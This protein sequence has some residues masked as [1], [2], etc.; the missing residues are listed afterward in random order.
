[1][2]TPSP[3][4]PIPPFPVE[5]ITPP[6]ESL[7]DSK[8]HLRALVNAEKLA[9]AEI[10]GF[11]YYPSLEFFYDV[12]QKVRG[13]CCPEG[14]YASGHDENAIYWKLKPNVFAENVPH[15]ALIKFQDPAHPVRAHVLDGQYDRVLELPTAEGMLFF[16]ETIVDA[17]FANEGMA[18]RIQKEGLLATRQYL[19]GL[20]QDKSVPLLH[21]LFGS[22]S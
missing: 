1:M 21:S 9:Y 15:Y 10:N 3:R 20:V 18:E 7:Y 8:G 11:G 19:V 5:S 14:M 4:K 6:P 12:E 13:F 22:E 17:V 16:P 2:D